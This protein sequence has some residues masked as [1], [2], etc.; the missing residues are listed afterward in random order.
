MK[1]VSVSVP[2][3]QPHAGYLVVHILRAYR[4]AYVIVCKSVHQSLVT[5]MLEQHRTGGVAEAVVELAPL[6]LA[7][8]QHLLAALV[9]LLG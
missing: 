7:Q 2:V 3:A 1:C 5:T 6:A 4:Y 9:L 8:C